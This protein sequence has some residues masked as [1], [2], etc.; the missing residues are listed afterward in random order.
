M[1]DELPPDSPMC[2][3]ASE[4]LLAANRAASLTNQLLVFSRNQVI[5]PIIVDLNNLV[6]KMYSD[7]GLIQ[8]DPVQIEQVI[9]NLAVNARDAMPWGGRLTLETANV[10]I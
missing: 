6:T 10:H 1:L 9:L 7:L 2:E 8:G 4:I 3:S 5:Q